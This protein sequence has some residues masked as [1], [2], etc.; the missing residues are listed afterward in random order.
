MGRGVLSE[1][2]IKVERMCFVRACKCGGGTCESL[3]KKA[4][5]FLSEHLAKRGR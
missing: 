2:R 3:A 4:K 5:S 1:N